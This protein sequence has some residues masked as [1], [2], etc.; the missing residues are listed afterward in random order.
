MDGNFVSEYQAHSANQNVLRSTDAKELHNFYQEVTPAGVGA[1]LKGKKEPIVSS[2]DLKQTKLE[3]KI[4]GVWTVVDV[5][6]HLVREEVQ[7]V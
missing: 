5:Q 7:S 3:N 4:K 1:Y 2:V 6:P